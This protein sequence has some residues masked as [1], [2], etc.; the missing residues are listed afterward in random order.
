MASPNKHQLQ[1]TSKTPTSPSKPKRVTW[2]PDDF[3]EVWCPIY[4]HEQPDEDSTSTNELQHDS[5]NTSWSLKEKA[6]HYDKQF[7]NKDSSNNSWSFEDLVQHHDLQAY[8]K[9][10]RF[11]NSS[12]PHTKL[13]QSITILQRPKHAQHNFQ[14]IRSTSSPTKSLHQRQKEYYQARAQIFNK[15]EVLAH[16]TNFHPP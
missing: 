10:R 12:L 15:T 3:L 7:T 11:A 9:E 1:K 13:D 2:K 8:L 14:T 4:N 6:H 16:P 5:S